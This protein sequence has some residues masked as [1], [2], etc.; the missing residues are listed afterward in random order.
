MAQTAIMSATFFALFEFWKAQ[1]KPEQH[2]A[3]ADALLKPKLW[4]KRRD[5]VWKRQFVFQ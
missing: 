4:R 3:P 5:H 1:L 2:R